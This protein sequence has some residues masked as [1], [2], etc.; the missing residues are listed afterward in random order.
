MDKN[1]IDFLKELQHEIKT[2]DHVSTAYPRFW[3]VVQD[4]EV[5]Y[6]D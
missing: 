5:N 2:Q 1:D 6:H 3:V 4:K